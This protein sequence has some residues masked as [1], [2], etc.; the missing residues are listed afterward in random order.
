MVVS[1]C[2]LAI[3][4]TDML[5]LLLRFFAVVMVLCGHWCY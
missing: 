4:L 5:W 1:G 3:G 2:G